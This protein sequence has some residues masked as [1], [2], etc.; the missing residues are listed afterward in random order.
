[1]LARKDLED[2]LGKKLTPGL[3]PQLK[4]KTLG[5]PPKV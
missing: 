1:M 2:N 4:I 3:G 5:N